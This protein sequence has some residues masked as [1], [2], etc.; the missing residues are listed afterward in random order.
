MRGNPRTSFRLALTGLVA[1][2]L[3]LYGR[4]LVDLSMTWNLD[5]NYSHGV[6][7]LPVVIYL[8]WNRRRELA[9]TE[10]RPA[11]LGLVIVVG[12]LMVLLVA[13]AGVEFF[14]MRMSV[15]GV[16]VGI[17]LFLAGWPWLR[18]LQFPL[19][20]SLLM[21]P[22]PPV[23]F[24]QIAFP[25]QLLATRFGVAALQLMRI[26]VLREGNVIA[27][28]HTTL[29]VTE[30]CSGIRSLVSLFALAVLYGYFTDPRRAPRILIAL[31]AIPIAIVANGLRIT[32]TGIAAQYLGPAATSGFLH[33]F[34]G[35]AVFV[36]SFLMLVA[37]ANVL[38]MRAAPALTLPEP[39][40]S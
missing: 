22:L 5:A 1:A 13:T 18:L 27:L 40:I 28:A 12:S 7:L 14:L 16:A 26:P 32:G 15:V 36:T 30:A 35:L 10:R 37:L 39:S 23:L 11:T 21:I 3:L 20:L 38:K 24:Y 25:L 33:T 31:S 2:F 9:A 6:L 29:E 4:L 34:S 17:V 19:G 8:V